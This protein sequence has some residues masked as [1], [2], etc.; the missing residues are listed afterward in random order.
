MATPP[1]TES[2]TAYIDAT[3]KLLQLTIRPEHH[4]GVVLQFTRLAALAQSVEA[5][6]FE[7]TDEPAPVFCPGN[8]P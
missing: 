3:A 5:H 1:D 7:M 4:D 6:P 2:I 8:T